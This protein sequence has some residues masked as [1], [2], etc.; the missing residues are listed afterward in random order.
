MREVN[1]MKKS[2]TRKLSI[3][4]FEDVVNR[5]LE[6]HNAAYALWEKGRLNS[7]EV[8]RSSKP[9]RKADQQPKSKLQ[10]A[11]L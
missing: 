9:I 5:L 1:Q 7:A 10:L 8:K 6:S 3:R 11:S 4:E 2:K